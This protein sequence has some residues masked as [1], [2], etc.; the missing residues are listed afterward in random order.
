MSPRTSEHDLR[1]INFLPFN[2]LSSSL[3]GFTV[4]V[5]RPADLLHAHNRIPL[6][7][8]RFIISHESGLPR[9]Y[10]LSSGN[11]NPLV[12]WMQ[13]R[14]E[15]DACRRIVAMS[16]YGQR[17]LLENQEELQRLDHTQHKMMV[18]HPNIELGPDEDRLKDDPCDKLVLTF[19]G[20]H[21]A[22]KGGCV[23][24][25]IAEQAQQRGLPIEVNIVSSLAVGEHIWTDPT[26]DGVFEPY[27][28]LLKLPNV[29]YHEYLP[30]DQA[31]ELLGRSHFSMLPTLSDTFGYSAI[32]GLA[33]HTPVIG[34]K[35]C[36]LPEFVDDG[37]NGYLFDIETGEAEAWKSLGFE[38]RAE[39]AYANHF[40]ETIDQLATEITARLE[41]IIGRKQDILR[42]R[43]NARLTA[44]TMFDAR[45][46]NPLWDTLYSRAAA[47]NKADPVQLDAMDD[48][49]APQN[50]RQAFERAGV[51]YSV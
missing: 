29:N 46:I 23:A 47:E 26:Q 6:I 42:L 25:R 9:R 19:I 1:S 44:E 34:T 33:E 48:M 41:T 51:E 20:G 17:C 24:V 13:N 32:E 30:N 8:N 35:V 12:K 27:L 15:S 18:R 7:S 5:G 28:E 3:D 2:S 43:R 31:R 10:G 40:N 14:L 4:P 45:K 21:F 36:A 22:R 16:H 11:R 50:V 39:A 38:R 37:F 49:C